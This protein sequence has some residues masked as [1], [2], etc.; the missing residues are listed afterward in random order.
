MSYLKDI[1]KLRGLL[2]R[3]MLQL[4]L[5]STTNIVSPRLL[6]VRVSCTQHLLGHKLRTSTVEYLCKWKGLIY[7][8]ATWELHDSIQDRASE[9][10]DSY[11]ERSSSPHLPHKS[12]NYSRGRPSFVK[13]NAEPDYI[14]V[15]GTLKDFQVTGLNWLAYLWSRGENGILADEVG[16]FPNTSVTSPR[17]LTL[18]ENSQM[19]L[20]KTVQTCAFLSY[21]YH[22]LNQYG[23]FLIVV[24]LSTLPAWQMQL[25]L[26][27]PDLNVIAY[28]GNGKSREM[29]RE[30]EFGAAKKVKFNVLLT[31]YEFALKDK[32]DLETIRWQYIAVDEV[33][34]YPIDLD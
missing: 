18:A 17:V 31:T 1:N 29:I 14:K 6:R 26:W 9:A 24:P 2:L 11:I 8:H 4:M 25:A 23:P 28:T 27:S 15:G 19:G 13:L 21:L 10:I 5:T 22:E 12:A 34:L 7:E 16:S 33:C 3:E 30:Y 32:E 20:G